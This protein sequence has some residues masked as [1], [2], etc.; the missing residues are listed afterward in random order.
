[1]LYGP[2]PGWIRFNKYSPKNAKTNEKIIARCIEILFLGRGLLLVLL[3]SLSKFLSK[4][5]LKL[6]ADPVTKKPPI[7]KITNSE[8]TKSSTPSI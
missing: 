6:F 5:W 4:I 7:I 2:L 3:I 1:M 8:K